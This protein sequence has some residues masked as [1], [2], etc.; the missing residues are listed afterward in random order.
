[1]TSE[2]LIDQSSGLDGPRWNGLREWLRLVDGIGE[3]R[4]VRGANSES[5]IG[6]VTELLDHTENSPCVLVDGIPGFEDG[7]RVAVNTQGTIRRQAITLGMDPRE[8]THERLMGYWRDILHGH[9]LIP[10]HEVDDGP[11]RQ[12]VQRGPDVDLTRFPAPI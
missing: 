6:N 12:H 1:M 5:D 9:H 11:I 3:L 8:V 4:V 2:A 10:P 7:Y